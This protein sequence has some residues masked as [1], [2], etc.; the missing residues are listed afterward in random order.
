MRPNKSRAGRRRHC[1]CG[2]VETNPRLRS[3]RK[4]TATPKRKSQKSG[5][6]ATCDH[7]LP[8]R[9]RPALFAAKRYRR[10]L[11]EMVRVVSLAGAGR[12]WSFRFGVPGVYISGRTR[13]KLS[14]AAGA[15]EKLVKAVVKKK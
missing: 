1:W 4:S 5:S 3:W 6:G 14:A 9:I 12:L 8:N 11:N 10:E 2:R 15:I 7:F 13:E